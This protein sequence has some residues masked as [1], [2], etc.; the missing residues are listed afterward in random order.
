MTS[1]ICGS[2]GSLHRTGASYKEHIYKDLDCRR[3]YREEFGTKAWVNLRE[4]VRSR[5]SDG[6]S[7]MRHECDNCGIRFNVYACLR[8]H[9]VAFSDCE[10]LY[11]E[12]LADNASA[13]EARNY[14][15]PRDLREELLMRD[16]EHVY[17][18]GTDSPAAVLKSLT[19]YFEEVV[20]Q[21]T[22]TRED[23]VRKLRYWA[24]G[25]EGLSIVQ[26]LKMTEPEINVV[27]R[28]NE[29]GR[30]SVEI[31]KTGAKITGVPSAAA[32]ED[33]AKHI[34]TNPDLWVVGMKG[35][36]KEYDIDNDQW[37]VTTPH[38]SWIGPIKV[39]KLADS[40]LDCAKANPHVNT[41]RMSGGG[42]SYT[43]V[44]N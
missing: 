33:M 41:F 28:R 15:I 37:Y 13:A 21:E 26:R 17:I 36:L 43:P 20:K 22:I 4:E 16:G 8:E 9:V 34:R 10:K 5:L 14:V 1:I 23:L 12:L 19:T 3:W 18:Q 39:E 25:A 35:Y 30:W 29:Y 44:N 27:I 2:C 40:L 32:A 38:Q 6:S 31:P 11:I 24:N 42:Y 7:Y